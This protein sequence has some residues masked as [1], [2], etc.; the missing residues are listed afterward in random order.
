M[1]TPAKRI[2][3]QFE[4]PI[5]RLHTN[6]PIVFVLYEKMGG[7]FLRFESVRNGERHLHLD[8]AMQLFFCRILEHHFLCIF[9]ELDE[10]KSCGLHS[11]KILP[12]WC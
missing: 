5:W 12:F 8:N 3:A 10:R 4:L 6:Y 2:K 7:H 11:I 1:P 9:K